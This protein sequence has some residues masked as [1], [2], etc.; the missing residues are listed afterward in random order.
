M[1]CMVHDIQHNC[2][3]RLQDAQQVGEKE[4]THVLRALTETLLVMG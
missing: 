1:R 2:P 3:F 4:Q